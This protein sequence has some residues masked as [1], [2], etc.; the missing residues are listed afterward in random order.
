LI[1][2]ETTADNDTAQIPSIAYAGSFLAD[3]ANNLLSPITTVAVADG[4]A[5]KI[6][7]RQTRDMNENGK[8]DAILMTTSENLNDNFAG[9]TASVGGYVVNNI[10]TLTGSDAQFAINLTETQNIDTAALPAV[11]LT[12]NASSGDAAGNLIA[13][14]SMSVVSTDGVGPVVVGARYDE[15]S[16]TIY[17]TFSENVATA[18]STSSFT[19]AGISGTY[20]VGSVVFTQGTSTAQIVLS[21]SPVVSYGSSTVSLAANTAADS[22]GNKQLNTVFGT[23]VASVVINE[24]MFSSTPANQYIELRNL[25]ASSVSLS[26]WTIANAGITLPSGATISANGYYLIAHD[27]AATS[28]L[29][30]TPDLITASLSLNATTQSDLVLQN[31]AVVMDSAKASPWPFGNGSSDISMERTTNP[32]NGI[33]AA[34]WHD[35]QASIGFDTLTPK[36]TPGS[37][38]QNDILAPDISSV[39]PQTATLFPQTPTQ[40]AFGYADVGASGI[41]SASAVVTLKKWNGATYDDVTIASL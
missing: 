37:V 4:V 13:S 6:L 23:I 33:L 9:L 30:V 1:I 11:A 3:V 27:A 21:G 32:G 7:S 20:S 36:G 25:S 41:D 18:L 38:N 19:L 14:D 35:G 2:G 28:I 31:G 5:P 24:V 17:A 15:S 40:L 12:S 26:G 29:N 10:T 22:A 39:S 8:I 16:K 34:N